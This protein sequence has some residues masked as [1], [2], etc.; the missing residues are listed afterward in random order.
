MKNRVDPTALFSRAVV[1]FSMKNTLGDQNYPIQLRSEGDLRFETLEGEEYEQSL[2]RG[3]DGQV[4]HLVD[5]W[6][7]LNTY[8][9]RKLR[10]KTNALT[11]YYRV[12]MEEGS[13]GALFYSDFL[14]LTIHHTGLVVAF[15]GNKIPTGKTYREIPIGFL[16]HRGWMDLILRIGNGRLE[17]FCNGQ[18]LNAIPMPH[19]LCAAFDDD[20]IIGA[21]QSCKPD[22]YDIVIPFD[23]LKNSR[24]DTVSI[25]H[26]VLSDE[27]VAALSGCEK[28]EV[29]LPA[30][31]FSEAFRAYNALFDASAAKD[32]PACRK[33]W[34]V[35]ERLARRDPT[36][37]VYHLTQPLGCI[38]DPCG[39]F[40]HNGKY[41]VYSYRNIMYLL[42]YSSLDH[43]VS[44]D[45]VHWRQQSIGPFADSEQDVF[46]IY[47]MNHFIDDDGHVRTLYTGQGTEGKCGILANVDD[48]MLV[49]DNKKAVITAYH[50][51][52]HV[53]K[54]GDTWYTITSK[55]CRG[56]R[57]GN[58][59][60]PVMLWSS[61]DLEHWKEE[62]EIFSQMKDEHNPEGFMEFP[63]LLSFG[64]KDVLILGGHPVK[65]WV[66]KFDWD[67][68]KFNADHE[69]G[70]LLDLSNPFHCFNPLCVDQKG[71]NGADRRLLM[72]LFHNISAMSS[73]Y[74][75]WLGTHVTPRV[76]TLENDHLRQDPI[77]EVNA[78]RG[79][80]T[81][82]KN[83]HIPSGETIDLP[84]KS[85]CIDIEAVFA[86]TSAGCFGVKVLVSEDKQQFVRVYYDAATNEFGVDGEVKFTGRGPSFNPPEE[87]VS[88]RILVDRSFVEVFVNGQSCT[89]CGKTP[90]PCGNSIALFAEESDC[91]C[92][93]ISVWN[94][95]ENHEIEV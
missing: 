25:W 70:I 76:L 14:S 38:Y 43:Y 90:L 22:T 88:I 32:L 55:L 82:L 33:A 27:E 68:L 91:D 62:G 93:Q 6:L 5:G 24:V 44:E 13:C 81:T 65:Y 59:G 56:T 2:L 86:P 21:F 34:N 48:E 69:K 39:A 66:G 11:V 67:T 73:R 49:Y 78:H 8:R 85:D 47:L 45:L 36:R 7:S 80:Q 3:S 26:T 28:I 41:H 83:L 16:H 52:G 40:Y 61:S 92:L 29:A 75:P 30:D 19:P 58:W 42:Q 72:A 23:P 89:T 1:T 35:M 57:E 60:N 37:P 54:R 17:F 77:P 9:A 20:M 87:K 64:E 31:D 12:H 94:N 95:G 71:E 51:D 50:H 4:V 10:P 46:C 63:Y 18:M 84:V 53:W 79:E 15:V 74:L